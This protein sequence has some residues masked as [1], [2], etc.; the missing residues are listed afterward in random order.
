MRKNQRCSLSFF[1]LL[2]LFVTGACNR[3]PRNIPFPGRESEFAEPATEKLTFREP[4]KFDWIT[5]SPDSSRPTETK[6]DLDKLPAKPLDMAF[7]KPLLSPLKDT[8]FDWKN[9]PDTVFN[10]DNIPAEKLRFHTAI[11]GEPRRVKSGLPRLKD[12]ASESLL[13]FGIDQGLSGTIGSSFV[14]DRNGIMWIGTDNGL[15]RFDGEYCEIYSQ[16]Q[17]LRYNWITKLFEDSRGQ[18]WICYNSNTGV[19]VLN[20]KTGLIKHISTAEGLASDRAVCFAEDSRGR[21]WV[22]TNRGINVID[23]KEGTIKLLRR[24]NGLSGNFVSGIF[25]DSRDRFWLAEPGSGISLIDFKEGRIK[26]VGTPQ[27]LGNNLVRCFD[28]DQDGRIWVGT[29]NKGLKVINE[30]KGSIKQLTSVNG[31]VSDRIYEM[32]VSRDGKIWIGT[33]RDGVD[34]YNPENETIIHLSTNEGLGNNNVTAVYADRQGQ[35]WIGTSGGEV[36]IYNTNG[37]GLQHL[38]S[39]RGLSNKTGFFYGFTEDSLSRIW[40]GSAGIIDVIDEKRGTIKSISTGEGLS[41]S[42][43]Q[44][45]YTDKRDRIWVSTGSDADV[46]DP[47][48]HIM[49]HFVSAKF[50]NRGVG[51]FIE[52][53]YGRIWMGSSNRVYVF[54]DQD[55]I[56]KYGKM[57]PGISNSFFQSIVMDKKEQTWLGSNNGIDLLDEKTGFLKHISNRGLDAIDVF[58]LKEDS[59]GNIWIGTNGNGLFMIDQTAGTVTHFT[60]A[61]GLEDMVVYTVD[62]RN[63]SIY[64][65]TGRGPA[66]L[67]PVNNTKD[68]KKAARWQIKTYGKPQGFLR[69]DHNPRSM[70]SKDGR[71][72]WG[73]ADVL[74]IMGEPKSDSLLSPTLLTAVDIMEQPQDFLANQWIQKQL[75]ETDTIWIAGK[76]TFYTKKNFPA[77]TGYLEK[78]NIRWDSAAGPYNIPMG[79]S[80]P[81]S[82]N[83]LTF[84]FTGTHLD[85]LNKTRYRYVLEGNDKTWSSITD[86][87]YADYRNLSHGK[88]TFKVSCRGFNGRWSRPVE[89]RFRIRPPWWLSAWAFVFY[90]LCL[91]ALFVTADAIQ[92]HRLLVRERERTREKELAQAKEIEKAYTELKTTQ[93]QLIQSEKMA[94]LGELT[95]GI[96]HE[97]QNPLNFV[98]NFS[99]VNKEML[100]EMREEIDKKNF[101]EVSA[102]AKNVEEN[103][104]KIIF[105]GKRADA[106]VKGMLQHSRSSTG[107][108]EPTDINALADEYL[109]LAY[110]GLRAK[111]KSFNA[112]LKTDFDESIGHIN[113]MPQDI[114]R[115]ILNLITNAFY[116]VNEKALSAVATLPTGQ[117]GPTAVKYEPTVS[118]STKKINGKV[119]IKVADN[120]NGI[121]Q[122]VL[123]KIFQPFFTTKPTGQGTGLGLSLSYDIVKAHGGEIKVNTK[124]N[125]G[126]EFIINLPAFE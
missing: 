19:G 63:G 18:I 65:G 55:T 124:E 120:G 93:A 74:T 44:Y 77:D 21:V 32:K 49:K 71:L 115:V 84:H 89:F 6:F 14:Q 103:E 24:G 41:N 11:L 47:G 38:T 119:E 117:A 45:L 98:N 67:T 56:M 83:H 104:E 22:G 99:E 87:A 76:D 81:S 39:A 17:G 54:N 8:V 116:V 123:D 59:R 118:V 33:S 48:A 4:Q 102:I 64:A 95:A 82:Q 23:E 101:E 30:K 13:L 126:T 75:K 53:R 27:G 1:Y 52:D 35:V 34:V 125:E 111:D 85:N 66:V 94:S 113:I 42:N 7:P 46:I 40:V 51:K 96:A 16:E 92:R 109:R 68:G 3:S 90:G 29:F 28:E 31:L 73:I 78:N 80:L 79:L 70:L 122:K 91:I 100:A 107:V 69:V 15:S 121:P 105:H 108:K 5:V 112:T 36:N 86:K 88:Y 110:H 20:K 2:I 37:G 12:G 50:A 97:I 60:N 72:W 25:K 26:R 58:D 9:I 114:G 61:D 57:P 10:L 62:E 43:T 106:I